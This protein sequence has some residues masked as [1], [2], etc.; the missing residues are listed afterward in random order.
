MQFHA[1]T[2][3][4]EI[5]VIVRDKNGAVADL[6]A[7]D[8]QLTDRGKPRTIAVFSK[9]VAAAMP[10]A[11]P[12]PRNTFSNRMRIGSAPSVTIVLLDRLNTLIETSAAAGEET[13]VWNAGLALEN[14]KE[15]ILKL[16]DELGPNDRVAIYTLG[17]SLTVLSDFTTDRAQLKPILE[18]FNAT[19]I[20]SREV[21]DP[22]PIHICPLGDPNGCPFNGPSNRDRQALADLA[23]ANRAAITMRALLAIA[24]HVAAIP[25]RKNL[26]W[27]T[28]DLPISGEGVGRVLSA[29]NLAI[30]P[31]DARGLLPLNEAHATVDTNG[32]QMLR[33]TR[34]GRGMFGMAARQEPPGLGAMREL[35]EETGGRAFLNTNDLAGAVHSAIDDGA[36]TYT[37]GF[38]A[39]EAALD[40]KFHELKVRVMRTSVEVRTQ[41]GYFASKGAENS[42]AATIASPMESSA[43][44]VLARVERD[45]DALSISGS[46]DLRNLTLEQNAKGEVEIFFVQQD[47]SGAMLDQRHENMHLQLTPQ[48]YQA[49]LKTGVFFRTRIPQKEGWKTLRIVAAD[50]ASGAAGSLIVP[51]SEIQ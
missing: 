7:G 39:D 23:N 27:L 36:V 22:D 34:T 6:T 46:I 48:Q 51:A 28:A 40:S 17:E 16:I 10:A 15:H 44:H 5:N 18:K 25:G 21:A 35:A 8:F 19:S 32:E 13:P 1:N 12:L 24:S 43:I 47:A 2:R 33:A 50:R 9:N 31:V 30:Y 37:L 45:G 42:Q 38:Y 11:A 4:V 26:V 49:Y 3:L 14:A 20:T 41:K 29:S